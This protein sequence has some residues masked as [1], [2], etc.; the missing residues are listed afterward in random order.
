MGGKKKGKGSGRMGGKGREWM[1]ED[2]RMDDNGFHR[3]GKDVIY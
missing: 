1:E 3:T 2:A